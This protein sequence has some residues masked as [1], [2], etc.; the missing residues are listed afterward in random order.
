[1]I[2]TV[3]HRGDAEA[4][5]R[6]EHCA[7]D[8]LPLGNRGI[9]E[10]DEDDAAKIRGPG[11]AAAEVGAGRPR[12]RCRSRRRDV[13]RTIGETAQAAR[14]RAEQIGEAPDEGAEAVIAHLEADLGDLELGGQQ[15]PPCGL[16][17][18]GAQE[19]AGRHAGELAKDAIEV[20]RAHVGDIGHLLERQVFIQAPAHCGDHP[21]HRTVMLDRSR[22]QC[23]RWFPIRRI[24]HRIPPS[25]NPDAP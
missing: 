24:T 16:Q 8:R 23:E 22:I 13:G 2:G 11:N 12:L 15:Q 14:R 17:T 6:P 18:Q 25:Q 1:M 7:G 4:A 19:L 20:E 3:G 5:R 10:A 9:E 21:L